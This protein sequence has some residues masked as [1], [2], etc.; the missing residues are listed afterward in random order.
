MRDYIRLHCV[1]Y[2]D[3]ILQSHG[4][5]APGHHESDRHDKP[6]LSKDAVDKLEQLDAG[7]IEGTPAHH[8]LQ[9]KMG[10]SFCQ[11][12]GELIFAMVV[13]RFDIGYAL[14]YL[15]RFATA[16]CEEHY[17]A[18]KRTCCYLRAR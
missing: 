14:S 1:Q 17:Q 8:A 3:R 9:S 11:V 18:L 4:W 7:P 13:C 15:S 2:I 6:P 12:M 16:P 10:F 5:A